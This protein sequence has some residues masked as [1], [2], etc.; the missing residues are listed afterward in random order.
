MVGHWCHRWRGGPVA[1]S[2]CKHQVTLR[3]AGR[4]KQAD[5]GFDLNVK[6]TAGGKGRTLGGGK[7]GGSEPR[8]DTAAGVGI[9]VVRQRWQKAWRPFK[10]RAKASR[11]NSRVLI[12]PFRPRRKRNWQTVLL[13]NTGSRGLWGLFGADSSICSGA[14]VATT[15]SLPQPVGLLREW[16]MVSM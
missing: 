16:I 11:E 2:V 1:V 6:R 15:C 14:D 13:D 12:G 7:A 4:G 5:S 10:S 9:L 8:R 3:R